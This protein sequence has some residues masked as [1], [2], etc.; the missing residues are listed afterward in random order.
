MRTPPVLLL[1]A[2][3]ACQNLAPGPAIVS[4][5]PAVP[6]T[7][8]DLV[9]TI[10]KEALDPEGKAIT[11]TYAWFKDGE[12]QPD[13]SGD[14]L[15]ADLTAKGETWRVEVSARDA[16]GEG[17][18]MGA[19]VSVVDTAPTVTVSITPTEPHSGDALV[20]VA[21][22]TDA[23]GDEVLLRWS[24]TRDGQVTAQTTDTV[25]STSTTCFQTW[26]V[27]VEPDDGEQIGEA[28]TASVMVLNSVP[29]LTSVIVEPT[30]PVETSTLYASAVAHDPD[31]DAV[32]ITWAWS[33]DGVT[34]PDV[35]GDTL[36]GA[37]FDKHQQ[38]RATATPSDLYAAGEPM[39]SDPVE[40]LNSPPTLEGVTLD[41]LE[42]YESSVVSCAPVGLSDPDGDMVDS[43]VSWLVNGA[44]V[45]TAA[46]LDGS[47]FSR[48]DELACRAS[49]TDGEVTGE[50][51]DSESAVVLN[52][53]PSVASVSL[54]PTSPAEGD[55]VIATLSGE[56]D[57][58]GDT[59]SLAYAWFVDGAQ[60]STGAELSSAF[61]SKHQDIL[62]E[63]TPSDGITTGSPVS[64]ATVTAVNTPPTF[65]N[66][67][68]TSSI[69]AANSVLGYVASGWYDADGD[70]EGYTCAW[71]VDGT[72]VSTAET[73]DL[74]LYGRGSSVS[75]QVTAWDGEAAGSTLTSTTLT[76]VQA[77][78]GDDA[79]LT[80]LGDR[81][82]QVGEALALLGDVTGD[83]VPDLAVGLPTRD[84]VATDAG[85]VYVAS[86]GL[87][88]SQ[89]LATVGIYLYGTTST[90]AAGRAL[91]GGADLT[92]DGVNDLLVG[93]PGDDSY[94]NDRGVVWLVD[95]PI[96]AG[97]LPSVAWALY[98]P[99]SNC[100]AGWSVASVGD[101][102]YDGQDDL[103]IGAPGAAGVGTDA[104]A[105]YLL[106]GPVSSTLS[107]SSADL[108]L[109]GAVAGDEAG[110]SV[111]GAGDLDGDGLSDLLIGAESESSAATDAG[112][113]YVVYGP[114]SGVTS[115]SGADATLLGQAAW[116]YAGYAVSGAGDVD[117]D[118]NDDLIVGARMQ[119]AGGGASGAAYL[120]YGP[121]TGTMSLSLADAIL[122][123]SAAGE[124]AGGS[125]AGLGD[126]DG[127]GRGE[128]A[129]GAVGAASLGSNTGIVY[130]LAGPLSGTLT[131][132]GGG[133]ASI[134][135]VHAGD[136]LGQALAGGMDGDGDGI[137][138]LFTA[139][140]YEDSNGSSSGA[141][142]LFGGAD[143]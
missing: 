29:V 89:N 74:S 61:F 36:D 18:S 31:G 22:V 38:V 107:L 20:A 112:A 67:A 62:L 136:K 79:V 51:L 76:I 12:R 17:P 32:D 116:D 39:T 75:V 97:S 53:P 111:A 101:V 57:D 15:P 141:A 23:D 2:A 24:W 7:L 127:D 121:V 4:L 129:V 3:T 106:F 98:G 113:V 45:S 92:G 96:T 5:S 52:S 142:Y 140:P 54:S 35:T 66:L 16:D 124:M 49:V 58:D 137:P 10:D 143:M 85:A 41:P 118:G 104:G 72:V 131:L 120:V 108:T 103:L 34:V 30:D 83:G 105:A 73:L 114:A 81:G 91:A 65:T 78:D 14:V 95:G 71:S 135:G 130:V 68:L 46:T 125:V 134:T 123:G 100:D 59:L 132:G 88:G 87:S 27:T 126:L 6:T 1:L 11:Y 44:E 60:V 90:G 115:L 64:S 80:L 56:H 19:E 84:V 69:A 21:E 50:V 99:T 82:D 110:W 28:A 43:D 33:V 139:A 119:D 13:A 128:I 133:Y 70:P 48:G 138:D 109:S 117:D 55:T 8:D 42:I 47:L 26:E 122:V 93:A 77:L 9:V 94:G 86:G 63:V 40:I 102:D 37:S 25:P